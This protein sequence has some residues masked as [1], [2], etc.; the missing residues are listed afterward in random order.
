[1]KSIKSL[2]SLAALAF[3]LSASSLASAATITPVGTAFT[4]PGTISVSSPASLQV[5]VNCNVTFKGTTAPD[6][7]YA[8]IDSVT[9]S[10]S[11]PLCNVPQMTGL[12]WRLT[13]S[14]VTSGQVDGVGFKILTSTCGP[15]TVYGAWSNATNTLS[16][17][18]QPLA[19]NCKI[20]SLSVNPSPAFTVNP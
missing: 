3:C 7:S 10:G 14:S 20:N 9:V 4:A 6:G 13:V 16:G 19:G 15:S 18:N 17:S 8:S 12:P 11:N 5:P 1:M 2:P